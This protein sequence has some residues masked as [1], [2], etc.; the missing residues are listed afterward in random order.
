MQLEA[1]VSPHTIA[2]CNGSDF[3]K[4]SIIIKLG[5]IRWVLGVKRLESKHYQLYHFGTE[6]KNAVSFISASP[7][8]VKRNDNFLLLCDPLIYFSPDTYS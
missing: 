8:V 3:M 7:Y 4:C 1:V 5:Y 6:I 2:Y